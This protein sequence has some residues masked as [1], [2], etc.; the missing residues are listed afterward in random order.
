M[1]R[2]LEKMGISWHPAFCGAMEMVLVS[3][4]QLFEFLREYP[5]SKEPLRMDLL[6]VKKLSESAPAFPPCTG[7]G[8]QSI[9]RGSYADEG[10]RRPE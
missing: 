9:C 4:K 2:N 8:C 10:S 5:L 6:I 1:G 7:G 3:D